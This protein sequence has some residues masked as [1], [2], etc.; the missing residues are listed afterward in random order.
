MAD[1]TQTATQD[2]EEDFSIPGQDETGAGSLG[3]TTEIPPVTPSSGIQQVQPSGPAAP[4]GTQF[5]QPKVSG[6]AMFLG[7]LLK[8]ILSGV[9]NNA[10]DRGFMAASPQAQ[11]AQKTA[12]ETAQAQLQNQLDQHQMNIV[13][14]HMAMTQDAV[15][16]H[17]LLHADD[18][19]Q[20]AILDNASNEYDALDGKGLI[21]DKHAIDGEGMKS[22]SDAVKFAGSQQAKIGYNSPERY[23]V[24]SEGNDLEHAKFIVG[25]V[26]PQDSIKD[27]EGNEYSVADY[28]HLNASERSKIGK[29]AVKERIKNLQDTYY[30][31]LKEADIKYGEE[32]DAQVRQAE[33]DLQTPGVKGTEMERAIM[34]RSADLK[35][36][37]PAFQSPADERKAEEAQRAADR[38][39]A[40]AANEDKSLRG[41]DVIVHSDEGEV[42][43]S[44]HEAQ[45]QGF[46]DFSTLTS[47]KA[48]DLKDKRANADASMDALTNYE[49]TFKKVRP[50]LS[51]ADRDAL[52]IITSGI[53]EQAKSGGLGEIIDNLPL[54]GP[55][56][57]YVN[58]LAK[59]SFKPAA[60][61]SLSPEGKELANQYALA[62]IS[63]FANMKQ[64]L[65]SIGRNPMM[66]Q[67]EMGTIPPPYMDPTTG[68]NALEL[69]RSDLRKRN[70]SIP[71]IYSRRKEAVKKG[72]KKL[73]GPSSNE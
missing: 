22:Y 18:A 40:R 52:K 70:E 16:A 57:E 71:E 43:M 62:Q 36:M 66:I 2:S 5:D 31:P 29:G 35:A 3:N 61:Q 69:K 73:A 54:A 14:M 53:D 1:P 68:A 42:L 7:N 13:K 72:L 41:K 4:Y 39:A 58:T 10:F 64:M 19:R 17:N 38:A 24:F 37:K 59:K 34:T 45:Q 6:R 56:S 44:A 65:G 46:D 63:N 12:Q 23:M 33:S 32:R 26:N 28:M 55:L 50:H 51:S 30:K 48:Q 21:Q 47:Q 9:Q 25:K 8:T 27:A 49:E 60:Y 11:Q 20:Q 67:A 15:T